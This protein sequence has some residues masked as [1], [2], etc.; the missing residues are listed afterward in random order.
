MKS[1]I[2]KQ[3]LRKIGTSTTSLQKVLN[4]FSKWKTK[5]HNQ[6][7]ENDEWKRQ[8]QKQ[9]SCTHTYNIKINNHEKRIVQKQDIGNVFEIKISA[10]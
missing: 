10:T 3:K 9:E 7:E 4:N 8:K 6:K 5:G 2:D 1:F